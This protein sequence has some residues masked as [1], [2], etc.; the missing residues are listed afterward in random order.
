MLLAT[1]DQMILHSSG[2]DLMMFVVGTSMKGLSGIDR[3]GRKFD[4][5]IGRHSYSKF[6]HV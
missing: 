5:V 6:F 4:L 2:D 3:K 1:F